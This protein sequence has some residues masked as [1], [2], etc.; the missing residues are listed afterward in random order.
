MVD[1][2]SGVDIQNNPT[3]DAAR[4]KTMVTTG[5]VILNTSRCVM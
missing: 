5:H 4:I 1:R 3:T 2:P